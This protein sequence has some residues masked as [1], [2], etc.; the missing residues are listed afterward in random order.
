M[1]PLLST[2]HGGEKTDA[3]LALAN[4][5]QQRQ[6]TQQPPAN[7]VRVLKRRSLSQFLAAAEI[8]HFKVPSQMPIL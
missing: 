6:S 4:G 1:S 2:P 7:P 8:F 3:V 5:L